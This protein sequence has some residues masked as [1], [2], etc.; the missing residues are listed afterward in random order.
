MSLLDRVACFLADR[1]VPHAL[2]GALALAVH[3]ISR[4]T[5]DEDLLVVDARVLNEQFWQPLGSEAEIRIT[6]G[7]PADPLAGV[8]RLRRE[9]EN[10]VDVV[11]GRH[12]WQQEVLSRAVPVADGPLRVV[13]VEDLILLKLFAGG[14][15]DKWDIEQLL[16]VH[17]DAGMLAAVDE[18]IGTLPQRSRDM[19]VTLRPK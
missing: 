5:R 19:W 12:R 6:Q 9:N 1:A 18:R 2:I 15:Q 17:T 14:S 3:G 10:Q 7:D 8:A 16:G 11:V 13:R 4:S